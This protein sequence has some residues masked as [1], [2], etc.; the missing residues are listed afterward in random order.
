MRNK[1]DQ[2]FIEYVLLFHDDQLHTQ[3]TFQNV[4]QYVTH[5]RIS[6]NIIMGFTRE[7]SFF[8]QHFISINA[9]L[10]YSSICSRKALFCHLSPRLLGFDLGEAMF[11]SRLDMSVGAN[12]L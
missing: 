5:M 12:R 4:I 1:R 7:D 10:D 2:V 6:H 9:V 8:S 11:F 3:A